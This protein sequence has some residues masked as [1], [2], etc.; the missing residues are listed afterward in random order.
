[1]VTYICKDIL[2][3]NVAKM[4]V[5]YLLKR[6]HE[7]S[8]LAPIIRRAIAQFGLAT[9]MKLVLESESWRRRGS[10]EAIWMRWLRRTCAVAIIYSTWGFL[11]EQ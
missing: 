2:K 11:A 10:T 3:F 7:P 1:M 4:D 8:H 9:I 6:L 5:N